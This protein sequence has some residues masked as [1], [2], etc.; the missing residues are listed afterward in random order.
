MNDTTYL[1]IALAV[2]FMAIIW[3]IYRR[4]WQ[5]KYGDYYWYR[6]EK[7]GV[8]MR[9]VFRERLL[10]LDRLVGGNVFKESRHVPR[11]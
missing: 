7:T 3:V 4:Q 2:I 6:D 5:P 8:V 9:T 10:D 11:G 1:T